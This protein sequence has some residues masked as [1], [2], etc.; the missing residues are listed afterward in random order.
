[1]KLL[2]LALGAVILCPADTNAQRGG[3][4]GGSD[5]TWKFLS[6]KYDKNKDGKISWKEYQR[7]KDKFRSLDKDG[8]RY[9]TKDDFGGGGR[10]GRRG[11]RGRGNRPRGGKV[12]Q[13][14]EMA[15]D[16]DLPLV[17]SLKETK[18]GILRGAT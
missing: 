17:G 5:R 11:G 10:G 15:P 14:G 4:R 12:P 6:K 1:M 3:R 2:L 18:K 7:D 8:D 9:I 13:R 16:F